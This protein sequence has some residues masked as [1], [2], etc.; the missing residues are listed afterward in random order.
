MVPIFRKKRRRVV[1]SSF[2]RSTGGMVGG[3]GKRRRRRLD[4]RHHHW[5][6]WWWWLP[7]PARRCCCCQSID[8]FISSTVRLHMSCSNAQDT[9]SNQGK[10]KHRLLSFLLSSLSLPH[11]HSLC[12]I[13]F[14]SPHDAF[15]PLPPPTLKHCTEVVVEKKSSEFFPS[16]FPS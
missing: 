2:Q 11:T 1:G 12:V 7:P 4:D 10:E 13:S 15:L 16:L 6:G 9:L 8:S 3:H 5:D 14:R